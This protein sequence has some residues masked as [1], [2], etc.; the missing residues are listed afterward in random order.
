MLFP[1]N[2]FVILVFIAS[3]LAAIL[4]FS[5]IGLAVYFLITFSVNPDSERKKND[6]YES[7]QSELNDAMS[8]E[9]EEND[10]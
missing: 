2:A 9:S 7:L 10:A 5:F 8:H 3:L 6:D 4:C 1:Y